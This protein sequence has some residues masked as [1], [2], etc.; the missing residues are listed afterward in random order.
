MPEETETLKRYRD[1]QKDYRLKLRFI[2]LLL[3]AGN[4][5]TE[6]VAAAVG[7]DIRTVETWY[8]KYLTHGPDA[9]NSFQYQPKRC[10]LSDDQ[11]ADMIAWVKKELPSDTKVICHYIREQTGIAYCQSAVAK[12]LKKKRTETTPSEADS[13]KTSV[14]KRT[15]RFY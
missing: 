11:L 6:I 10:F 13:G 15:N 3:I 5:G 4:T 7:K 12:L 1:G 14:R 2:A 8:G 9:L